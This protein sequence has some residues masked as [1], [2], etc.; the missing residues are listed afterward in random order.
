MPKT[1]VPDPADSAQPKRIAARFQTQLP[2][3]LNG[4]PGLTQNISA[5]GVYFETNTNAAPGSEVQFV[6]A[7]DMQGEKFN[8]VCKGVVVRVD[9][10]EDIKGVAVKLSNSFFTDSD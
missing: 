7:V 3:E 1:P 5:T 8:M 10:K 6:V 9:Q 4:T 2:I